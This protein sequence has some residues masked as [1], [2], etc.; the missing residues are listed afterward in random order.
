M[1][2]ENENDSDTDGP[3][4]GTAVGET[5]LAHFD[6]DLDLIYAPVDLTADDDGFEANIVCSTIRWP[7]EIYP[8]S[9]S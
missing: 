4:P 3:P 5:L 1:A 6:L 7:G 8:I 2:R 9:L